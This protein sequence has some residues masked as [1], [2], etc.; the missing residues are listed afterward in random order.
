MPW[1]VC[2]DQKTTFGGM[3]SLSYCGAQGLN[4]DLQVRTIGSTAHLAHLSGVISDA[5]GAAQ[6]PSLGLSSKC[7]DLTGAQRP[8]RKQVTCQD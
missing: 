3:F 7:L 4:S 6:L 1:P 8:H 2:G 5:S